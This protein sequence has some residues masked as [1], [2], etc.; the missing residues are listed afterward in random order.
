[1]GIERKL[2]IMTTMNVQ[3]LNMMIVNIVMLK[4]TLMNLL[5]RLCRNGNK[6][7]RKFTI[8]KTNF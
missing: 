7:K 6:L 4:L 8:V 3:V 5:Q 1:M 2:P